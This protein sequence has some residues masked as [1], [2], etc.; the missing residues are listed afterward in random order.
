MVNISPA[1]WGFEK[2]LKHIV[3]EQPALRR[4]AESILGE[5]EK[6][7]SGE[8]FGRLECGSD[9]K[10]A[11]LGSEG[12]DGY[13]LVET[14]SEEPSLLVLAIGGEPR[15]FGGLRCFEVGV[16]IVGCGGAENIRLSRSGRLGRTVKH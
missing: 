4:E 11:E 15:G 13:A 8:L 3:G 2:F 6:V 12:G 5:D 1:R 16:E 7:A 9:S 10:F 14:E